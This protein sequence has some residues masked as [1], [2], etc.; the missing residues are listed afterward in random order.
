VTT[1]TGQY[2][3]GAWF[4]SVRSGDQFSEEMI[5]EGGSRP[6]S[7]TRPNGDDL[8]TRWPGVGF[9]SAFSLAS[10]FAVLRLYPLVDRST[11]RELAQVAGA[12]VATF[13]TQT[14][15]MA[16]TIDA[17]LTASVAALTSDAETRAALAEQISPL[18][19]QQT[20]TYWVGEDSRVYRAAATLVVADENGVPTPW[21]EVT[22]R[23]W[24]YD[25]ARIFIEI[26]SAVS[27]APAPSSAGAALLPGADRTLST[28]TPPP[29]NLLVR[30]FSAPGIPAESLA[31][32]VFPA[33]DARQFIDWRDSAEAGFVLPAGTYDVLVQ[34]DYA[35]EWLRDVE[36]T[37]G[38]L[39]EREVVFDFGILE[40]AVTLDGVAVPVEIVTYPAGDRQN[41]VDWASDNPARMQLREGYYDI[42][43]AYADYSATQTLTDLEVLAGQINRLEIEL[44]E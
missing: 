15:F 39:A 10:P 27:D 12:P 26:P 28:Q 2:R 31:V 7:Y 23:F 9:D 24:A 33:G 29:E 40:L 30:T 14:V 3:E 35:Q 20:I 32:S 8:W 22:W 5:V 21:L 37:E 34:M 25:D 17:L 36:V 43:I 18:K 13:R 41:W 38:A 19:T 44:A 16:T 42:E 1:T 4:Q 6:Q 11:P